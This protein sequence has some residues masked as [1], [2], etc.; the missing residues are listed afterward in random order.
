M[1][2][3][4]KSRFKL[5]LVC[6]NKLFYTANKNYANNKKGDT[7]LMALASGGFQIE[8]YAR[9]HFLGGILIDGDYKNKSYKDF[10]DETTE[11]L[12]QENIIIYE[13]AFL[14][15]DLFIRADILIKKGNRIELIEVKSK[16]YDPNNKYTFVGKKRRT[17]KELET[18]FI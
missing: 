17:S 8:E 15:E 11:L 3:I 10:A 6:P 14:F 2:V 1:K 4:S 7:F 13:A 16:S 18:L 12:K 5:G 9:M